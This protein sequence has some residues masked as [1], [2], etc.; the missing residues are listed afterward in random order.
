M[1]RL[2]SI[3]QPNGQELHWMQLPALR[4]I[5]APLAPIAAAPSIASCPLRPIRLRVELGYPQGPLGLGVVGAHLVGPGDAEALAPVGQH[6]LGR[7]EAGAG[8]DHGGAA[9]D[10]GDRDRDR[11]P[12]FGDRQAAVAVELGDRVEVVGGIA[13]AVV[14]AAG[15]EHDHVE[16][17]RRQ[18]GRGDRAAGAGADDDDVAFLAVALRLQVAEAPRRLRQGPVG[19]GAA[20][21]RSR[22]APAPAGSPRSRGSRRAW[23]SA[24]GRGGARTCEPSRWSQEVLLRRPGRG[25]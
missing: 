7:A 16:P 22:S 10:L 5:G 20:G 12:A 9:D 6:R 18:L 24:A 1:P 15:L 19:G 23:P 17:G 21:S 25:G 2:A 13:V 4:W 3:S 8:V 11:R 14:V